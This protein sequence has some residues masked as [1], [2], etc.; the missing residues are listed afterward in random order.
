M[1]WSY[2]APMFL[3]VLFQQMYNLA[4]SVIA[5]KFAGQAALAAVG[6]SNPITMIFV[7][8]GSGCNIGCAV[9]I[10]RLFGTK[11]Y[12][13]MKTAVSTT[14]RTAVFL[15]V[16]LT[17]IGVL[18]N[19]PL[20]RLIRT[21]DD[22][23]SQAALYLRIYIFGFPFLFLYNIA[24]GIFT[25]LG[26]SRTPLYFLIGSSV[27]NILLDYVFVAKFSWDVAGVAWATFLAQGVA[28]ILALAVLSRRLKDVRSEE[29]HRKF[30]FET[31]KLTAEVA[32][33]SILQQSFI[34]IGNM[35]VQALINGYGSPVIAGSSAALKVNAIAIAALATLSNGLSGFTAQNFGAGEHKRIREGFFC[36]LAMAAG[37]GAV[38]SVGFVL[39]ADPMIRL[40]M[41]D[42][43]DTDT[44]LSVGVEFLHIV[45]PCYAVLSCKLISDGVLRGLGCMKDFMFSTFT[46]LLLRT[47]L[48]YLF[49]RP[50]SPRALWFSWPI[51]WT[52]STVIS[53]LLLKKRFR[54]RPIG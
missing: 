52:I 36:G 48:C 43:A 53:L 12:G 20:M 15:A 17:G 19:D 14:V 49:F 30:S 45:S 16:L 31:L 34:S 39:G 28:C 18:F 38:L 11:E 32:V 8:V 23:F 3:S 35:F 54:E 29:E 7:A 6:A 21:P 25:A 41:E 9:V 37:L 33:P 50:A 27:G 1:L 5:G 26:D 42:S 46:D 24:T 51:G 4:D 13:K 22:I 40:F 10:S 44:A 2:S 47:V